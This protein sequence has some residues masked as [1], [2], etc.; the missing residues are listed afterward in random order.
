MEIVLL[1]FLVR[2]LRAY[3][4]APERRGIDVKGEIIDVLTNGQW[5]AEHAISLEID[6][7]FEAAGL[8]PPRLPTAIIRSRAMDLASD[9][10]VQWRMGNVEEDENI[11]LVYYRLRP[12]GRRPV[13]SRWSLPAL[14]PAQTIV[15]SALALRLF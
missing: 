12:G 14:V 9:R 7:R 15:R 2:M 8:K 6:Q 4:T 1:V 3:L 10:R 5:W 11:L 13:E